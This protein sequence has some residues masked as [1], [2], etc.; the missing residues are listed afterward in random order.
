MHGCWGFWGPTVKSVTVG[1][2]TVILRRSAAACRQ[3]GSDEILLSA[4]IAFDRPGRYAMAGRDFTFDA[5]RIVMF[6]MARPFTVDLGRYR[7]I[8]FRLSRSLIGAA[9]G[10]DPGRLAGHVL[11]VTP[12]TSLL[13]SHLHHVADALPNMTDDQRQVALDAAT[14]FALATLRLETGALQREPN[15]RTDWLWEAVSRYIDRHLDQRD[16][17][18]ESLARALHCSR[19]QIY[20]LFASRGLAVMGHIQECRLTRAHALLADPACLMPIADIAQLCGF[21][22]PSSFSRG[23][24]RRFGCPPREVRIRAGI[25]VDR[26]S[27]TGQ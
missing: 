22:D 20:R 21:E 4:V 16:L 26:D 24:R 12:L 17:T 25:A 23:F 15:E 13:F 11:P 18:P 27:L 5:G 7:E 1:P 14:D 6:D 8:N 19:A 3:D 9:I 2:I 10:R